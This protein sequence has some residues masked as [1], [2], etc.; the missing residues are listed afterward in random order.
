M[1]TVRLNRMRNVSRQR[2]AALAKRIWRYTRF[3]PRDSF[4]WEQAGGSVRAVPI[5][6]RPSDAPGWV[7]AQGRDHE[8]CIVCMAHISPLVGYQHHGF[9]DGANWLCRRCYDFY[10]GRRKSVR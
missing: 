2:C 7:V 1:A 10:V 4:H 6:R 9:T 3:S 5:E 8:H